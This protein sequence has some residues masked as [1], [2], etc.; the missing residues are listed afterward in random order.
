[1]KEFNKV[2]GYDD[3]KI[4]LIRIVDMMLNPNKF[5]DLGVKTT[6]GLILF[7]NPGVG[8]TLMAKCFIKAS[9][10]KTYTIRKDMP[11]GEF[12]SHIKKI[13]EKAKKDAPSIVFLDDLDK[14]ANED[15]NHINAEEFVTIQS[16]IDDCNESEVF[17]LATANE[18]DCIPRSLIR[19]GRIDKMIFVDPPKAEDA[20][21]IIKYYLKDKK[22]SK[23]LDY[24]DIASLLDGRTCATLETVLN[25]AG[26][27]AGFENRQ[28]I[29]MKDIIRSFMRIVY[30]SPE[31]LDFKD[32]KYLKETAY[33]EAGHTVV[34]EML[35]KD[36]IKFV[37]IKPHIGG[38]GGF[39]QFKNNDDYFE[40]KEFM[41]KR[42]ISL[43]AGKAAIEVV[44]G[45]TDI[46]SNSDIHRAVE[47]VK[48]FID[49]YCSFGFSFFEGYT[50]GGI[51]SELLERKTI[52]VELEMER[53]YQKAKQILINN[54]SFLD[55][56]AN[57]L[58]KKQIL[59]SS[60]IQRL[61]EAC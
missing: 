35:E 49:T 30:G 3:I 37:S 6:R 34:G 39:A 8:K 59:L 2:I 44:Y 33:H 10:R 16:C 21:K 36:S 1:M 22:C 7:G 17:V 15:R 32:S 28:E 45:K 48:R 54:R 60:D 55:N 24:Y 41:E 25:E 43:L 47:I 11:D 61:R 27:Y 51:S 53:Y 9:K 40:D 52:A 38:V 18:D 58:A 23:N 13:F 14:F 56:V 57:E 42:V 46:G 26:I 4:E 5:S 50:S 20:A 29:E 19:E 12:V 31:K